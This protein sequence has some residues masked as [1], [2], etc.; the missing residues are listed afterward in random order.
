VAAVARTNQ[1][2]VAARTTSGLD[3][4]TEHFAAAVADVVAKAVAG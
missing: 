1:P 2:I 4:S 3:A